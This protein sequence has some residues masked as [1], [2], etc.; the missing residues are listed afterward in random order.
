VT[1]LFTV[2]SQLLVGPQFLRNLEEEHR[3][4]FLQVQSMQS[5]LKERIRNSEKMKNYLS[6]YANERKENQINSAWKKKIV[7]NK[8]NIKNDSEPIINIE[9][10]KLRWE[11][12][13][14]SMDS[15]DEIDAGDVVNRDPKFIRQ[16]HRMMSIVPHNDELEDDE[17]L[18]RAKIESMEKELIELGNL[19]NS[20]AYQL[21]SANILNMT[22]LFLLQTS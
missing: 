20:R 6:P 11:A 13:Q 15:R 9:A 21:L 8:Q 4:K 16:Y 2:L 3:E 5:K 10:M 7:N 12:Q 18:V 17:A 1:H 19:N 14:S 22:S